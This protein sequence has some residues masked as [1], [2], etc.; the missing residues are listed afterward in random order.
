VLVAFTIA[1]IMLAGLFQLFSTELQSVARADTYTR[2]VLLAESRLD[3]IG[4]A[5]PLAAGT[6]TGRFDERFF[7]KVAVER[8][9]TDDKAEAS[10]PTYLYRVQV[11]VSWHEGS[12]DSAVSLESLR[13]VL[14]ER[15]RT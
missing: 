3:S 12:A 15:G 2:A 5:E 11:T 8:Y 9:A 10:S 14:A 1:A 7:W 4:I 6:T 13:M